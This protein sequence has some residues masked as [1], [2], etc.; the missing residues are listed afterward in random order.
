[1][2]TT[3]YGVDYYHMDPN[4]CLV[5]YANSPDCEVVPVPPIIPVPTTGIPAPSLPVGLLSNLSAVPLNYEQVLLNW[6]EPQS[7]Y[8]DWRLIRS[9]FGFPVDE[10]DGA[11]LVDTDS[12]A[13][14][15]SSYLDTG[16]IPGSYNYYAIYLLVAETFTIS[17]ATAGNST[18][19]TD[20]A[21]NWTTNMWTGYTVTITS[22]T[23]A[24][25]TAVVVSNTQTVL[26]V[27]S[28]SGAAPAAS[29]GYSLTQE[30]WFRSGFAACLC[31]WDYESAAWIKGRIPNYFLN[32]PNQELTTDDPIGNKTLNS[33]LNII[34]W[35]IDYLKT[36]LFVA[37]NVNNPQ[38]IP[39]N[40]LYNLAQQLGLP[41]EPEI[42]TGVLR[43]AVANQ[44]T[45]IK[46]RGT[47]EGI[48]AYITQ[49]TGWGADIRP[50]INLMLEDDQAHFIDPQVAAYS[51]TTNYATGEMVTYDNYVYES[52]VTN[53]LNVAP[54]G[55]TSA[56][57]N[58]TC[59]YYSSNSTLLENATTGWVNTWEPRQLNETNDVAPAGSLSEAV[60]ILDRTHAG[61]Y[62]KNGLLVTNTTGSA[63]TLDIQ[64]ISRTTADIT[65]VNVYANRTQVIGDGLPVPYTIPQQTWSSTTQYPTG[66]I[67]TYNGQPFLALKS[68]QNVAPPTNNVPTNEWQPIGF[69]DRIALMMSAYAE[70]SPV[71]SST[72]ANVQPYAAWYD[73][74]GNHIT[75][76]YPRQTSNYPANLVYSSWA[77]SSLWGAALS[78]S[79][80]DVGSFTWT[81][82]VSTFNINGFEGGCIYPSVVNNR[83]EALITYTGIT[84]LQLGLTFLTLPNSSYSMGLVVRWAI[85]GSTE[86]Y[87][88]VDQNAIYEVNGATRTKQGS[89]HTTVFAAGDRM[90]VTVSS[91]TLT[92]Y[93][94]NAPTTSNPINLA[95]VNSCSISA[96][97]T[98]SVTHGVIVEAT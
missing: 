94:Y 24:G 2:A 34:G 45:L 51:T 42:S 20:S 83:T 84:N 78:G 30:V 29:S 81:A 57:A 97:N 82:Q 85:A 11:V 39:E 48:E 15:G 27:T 1:M 49:L 47:L 74:W 38:V 77:N 61:E 59:L 50:G 88:R 28:W 37:Q 22:G 89:N 14:P 66:A 56:N 76:L 19:L 68:S 58:W 65:A 41:Y 21:Q 16:V 90:I 75:T 95:Q 46:Q 13:Y 9:R 87:W 92:V 55:T 64:S 96:M 36:A 63:A 44:S 25:S 72:T 8:L 98:S 52:L 91:N 10:N 54:T 79:A 40:W 35:G 62:Q 93:R 4:G 17:T 31:P 32:N 53:N 33:Y 26:T 86:S 43:G 7:A 3:V 5:Y 69:D 67:V 6:Q 12:A 71:T 18:T 80:P 70:A 60:G 73:Q 23:G